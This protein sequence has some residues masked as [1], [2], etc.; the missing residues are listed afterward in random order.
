[1]S[2]IYA[3]YSADALLGPTL[4]GTTAPF[5]THAL[6]LTLIGPGNNTATR[7]T[8]HTS[9][10][11]RTGSCHK[12]CHAAQVAHRRPQLRTVRTGVELYGHV[13][14]QDCWRDGPQRYL[15]WHV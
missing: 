12:R 4:G 9:T 5:L 1:M 7:A 15:R 13:P 2:R 14:M 11:S 3:A 10:P 6:L 8:E